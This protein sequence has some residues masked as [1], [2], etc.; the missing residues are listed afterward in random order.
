VTEWKRK[1]IRE[2]DKPWTDQWMTT[3]EDGIVGDN[4]DGGAE[5]LERE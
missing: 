4:D 3:Y 5:A 2:K 1:R